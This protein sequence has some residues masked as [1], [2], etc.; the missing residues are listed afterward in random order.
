MCMCI[1]MYIIQIL[2][3]YVSWNDANNP[4]GGS[5]EQIDVTSKLH[6]AVPH[7]SPTSY[8][9]SLLYHSSSQ[10]W[11]ISIWSSWNIPIICH[12]SYF[13]CSITAY[14]IY[15]ISYIIHCMSYI[16]FHISYIVYHIS[17]IIYRI[18]FPWSLWYPH[19][20]LVNSKKKGNKLWNSSM[21]NRETTY[22]STCNKFHSCISHY[23]SHW[24]GL[25]ENLQE[26]MD[27]LMKY[28]SFL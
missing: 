18:I 24:V 7:R 20:P 9:M 19:Y 5:Y 10:S 27:F 23:Q 2:L 14:M 15:Q 4:V 22:F 6:L 12:M 11:T 1:Y 16:I 17:Y 25:R 8:R 21:L 13:I 26:N 3:Y 28:G